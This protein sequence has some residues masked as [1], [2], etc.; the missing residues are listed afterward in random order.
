MT[1]RAAL[2]LLLLTLLLSV[3]APAAMAGMASPLPTDPQRVLRLNE[4]PR[5]RLQAISF[6][7]LGLLGCAW[8][9]ASY[10]TISSAIFRDCRD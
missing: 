1:R 9:S 7:V 10:G 3:A 8:Q 4:T 2:P 6:F 5:Q